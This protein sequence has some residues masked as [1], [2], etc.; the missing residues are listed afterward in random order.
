MWRPGNRVVDWSYAGYGA[1]ERPIPNYAVALNATAYGLR[2]DGK[3]GAC[4]VCWPCSSA[5]ATPREPSCLCAPCCVAGEGS[6]ALALA[7]S[8]LLPPAL[9]LPRADVSGALQ[10]LLNTAGKLAA[11]RGVGVA[12]LVPRGVYRLDKPV[13]ISHANVTLRGEGV[14]GAWQRSVA[15]RQARQRHLRLPEPPARLPHARAQ[16]TKT[17]FTLTNSLTDVNGDKLYNFLG[18]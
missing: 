12:V 16:P 17:V 8:P 10:S 18:E 5:H 13:T 6:A 2:G 1:A 11:Q 15:V 3:A 4:A 7:H 9:L 14:S